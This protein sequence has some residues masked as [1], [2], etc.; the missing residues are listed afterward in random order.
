MGL[1]KDCSMKL[2]AHALIVTCLTVQYSSLF[3]RG[4]SKMASV[5]VGGGLLGSLLRSKKTDFQATV[6]VFRPSWG[7]KET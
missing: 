3:F 6:A 2:Q 5:I 7:L 1:K 4:G